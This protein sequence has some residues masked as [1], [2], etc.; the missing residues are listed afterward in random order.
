MMMRGQATSGMRDGKYYLGL[1]EY[2]REIKSRLGFSPYPGTLNIRLDAPEGTQCKERLSAMEGIEIPG[3]RK[4]GRMFG[5][6]RCFSCLVSGVEG[7]V[8]IP[9]RSHYGFEVL[10]VI[11]PH[12]LRKKLKLKDG[13]GVEVKI[14][15]V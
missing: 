7:A 1:D 10:E 8:L 13:D 9:E 2:V 14:G 15:V 6:I 12:N 11:S 5:S 3:F 4:G